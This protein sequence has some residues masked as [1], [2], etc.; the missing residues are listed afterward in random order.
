MY[1]YTRQFI[2]T[3]RDYRSEK[4]ENVGK[5]FLRAGITA[6]NA[7]TLSFLFGLFAVYYLFQNHLLFVIFVLLHLLTDALDG[8]IA[9]AA[10]PTTFGKYLDY[11]T[12]QL[13]HL[14][15]IVKIG[16]YLDDYYAFIIAGLLIL[17][18]LV[19][20]LSKCTA[21]VLFLRTVTLLLLSLNIPTLS[22]LQLPTI[23]YLATGVTAAYSLMLQVQFYMKKRDW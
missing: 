8:V 15:T 21:P 5:F 19:Y 6:N 20:I 1:G 2:D 10:S 12:D 18:Q 23:A 17:A 11:A 16:F 9:R 4:F 13:I 22:F 7:T 14:L 3:F